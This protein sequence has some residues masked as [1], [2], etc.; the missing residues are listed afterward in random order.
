MAYHLQQSTPVA[1]KT[2]KAEIVTKEFEKEV[3]VIWYVVEHFKVITSV[4]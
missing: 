3:S 4:N 2:L 1:L